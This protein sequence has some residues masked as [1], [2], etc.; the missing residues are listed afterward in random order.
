MLMSACK[1][2]ARFKAFDCPEAR[3]RLF[4][5]QLCSLSLL[6]NAPVFTLWPRL[7]A[8]G[9]RPRPARGSW[10]RKRPTGESLAPLQ[11]GHGKRAMGHREKGLND[12][13]LHRVRQPYN[14]WG[15][16]RW[17]NFRSSHEP[18]RHSHWNCSSSTLL[19]VCLGSS[20][21]QASQAFGKTTF[22]QAH[23]LIDASFNLHHQDVTYVGWVQDSSHVGQIETLSVSHSNK[24]GAQSFLEKN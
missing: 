21:V 8:R 6:C 9:Q 24:V 2:G 10:C 3:V 1:C 19:L 11:P 23:T 15:R 13:G 22:T 18:S 12:S 4:E 16:M 7:E 17:P 5:T 20:L 14:R